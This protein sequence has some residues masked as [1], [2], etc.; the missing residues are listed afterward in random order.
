MTTSPTRPPLSII[1]VSYNTRALTLDCLRTVTAQ[2]HGELSQSEIWLVD[3]ASRDGSAEAVAEEFPTVK[4][5]ANERNVGFG[6]ANNQ[7]L[8]QARGKYLLLLNSDAFPLAGALET[9]CKYLQEH[10]QVGAVGPR[11]LNE[12]GTLQASCWKFPTPARSWFESV[13][14]G[15]R[16]CPIIRF[17]ATIIAGSTMKPKKLIS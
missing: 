14:F 9:L 12:D 15:R 11:L 10:P 5:I 1:I 3:N 6:A 17:S 7:A 16:A 8:Q 13:G 2:L 4:L